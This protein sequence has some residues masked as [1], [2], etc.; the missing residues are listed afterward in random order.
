MQRKATAV[1]VLLC[2]IASIALPAGK[3]AGTVYFSVVN[4]SILPLSAAT[5]PAYIEGQL[6]LPY[7][8]FNSDELGVYSNA[9]GDIALIYFS[10]SKLLKFDVARGT[11]FNQNDEQYYRYNAKLYNGIIY[12]PVQLVCDFF[13]FTHSVI[14]TEPADIVRV[15]TS[16]SNI[17]D[18]RFT[19]ITSIK[20]ELQSKYDAYTGNPGAS[21][22]PTSSADVGPTY[23]NVTVFLNFFDISSG[24]LS[25]ILD[26]LDTTAYNVCIF[27]AKDEIEANATLLRR[28]AGRGHMIGIWLKDGTYA[29][30]M[31]ASALLFEAAKVKT[32]IVTAGGDNTKAAIAMADAAQLVFWLSTS[33]YDAE[34]KFSVAGLT[35]SLGVVSGRQSIAF[36]CSEKTSFV[37]RS[38]LLYLNQQKYN[39]RPVN[40]TTTPIISAGN[41]A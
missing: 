24:K 1:L 30:Y 11:V 18:A 28:A 3:A 21:A 16:A 2:I 14:D 29:E 5:M 4:N 32:V 23:Q 22:S 39:V 13:G 7:S 26:T 35:G 37:L 38:F 25:S 15:R 9:G 34:A 31:D 6:Y 17:D 20:D 36:A 8:F 33:S 27:V 10:N 12:V 40:E 19:T 41:P